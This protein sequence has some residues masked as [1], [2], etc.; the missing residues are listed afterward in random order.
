MLGHNAGQVQTQFPS[1]EGKWVVNPDFERGQLS[2]IL[3]GLSSLNTNSV[4]GVMLF[5]IDHP[6]VNRILIN[7]LIESFDISRGLIIIPS[8]E[9]RRGHP[10]IFS[11]TLFDELSNA[12][13]DRGALDVVRKHQKRSFMLRSTTL[14]CLLTSIHQRIIRGMW[15]RQVQAKARERISRVESKLPSRSGDLFQTGSPF[16]NFMV[17]SSIRL[18]PVSFE[19]IS[20]GY[21]SLTV[22]GSGNSNSGLQI[23]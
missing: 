21:Y 17:V 19:S 5:L 2:S 9:H 6:F 20:S 8:Y 4:D 11:R 16:L 18:F 12:S 23:L 1:L 22:S 10:V 15:C 3:C 7:Q 13:P 14:V